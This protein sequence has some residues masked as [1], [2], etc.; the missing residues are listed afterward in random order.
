MIINKNIANFFSKLSIGTAQFGSQ[1]GVT[2]KIGKVNLNEI[3]K[4]LEHSKTKFISSIDTSREYLDSEKN[5][6]NFNLNRFKITTK[7]NFKNQSIKDIMNNI[8]I[9]IKNLKLNFLDSLLIH[10]F[11]NLNH[12]EKNLAF[13]NLFYLKNKKILKKIG[14]STYNFDNLI[15]ISNNYPIDIIQVPF[16]IFDK[17]LDNIN[18]INSLN[19]NNISLQVRSIFLQGLLINSSKLPKNVQKYLPVFDS[20][21][22]FLK[23]NDYSSINYCINY[24]LSKEYIDNIIIGFDSYHQFLDIINFKFYNNF[25]IFDLTTTPDIDHLINPNKWNQ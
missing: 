21:N 17:R 1:Y 4:I 23:I 22:E 16:N 12:Y 25:K 5:L 3:K 13:K 19:N 20:W 18:I 9:S 7:I 15:S 24:V 6:G 8:N 14:I 2:N 10:D 11:D